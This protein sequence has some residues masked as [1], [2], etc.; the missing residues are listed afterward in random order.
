LGFRPAKVRAIPPAGERRIAT[1]AP[2]APPQRAADAPTG[3]V[4]GS[5]PE[6]PAL[7]DVPAETRHSGCPGVATL[8]AVRS[9]GRALP[10]T[11]PATVRTADPLREAARTGLAVHIPPRRPP[12]DRAT[13]RRGLSTG[14]DDM[15]RRAEALR[16][17]GHPGNDSRFPSRR[18]PPRRS[19]VRRSPCGAGRRAAGLAGRCG[20]R[21]FMSPSLSRAASIQMQLRRDD[22]NNCGSVIKKLLIKNA[23]LH[24]RYSIFPPAYPQAACP[25]ARSQPR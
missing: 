3:R 8:A 19:P 18:R 22:N 1:D 23:I 6:E 12:S 4:E 25:A 17:R 24:K 7:P 10:G 15:P 21:D 16:G 11:R 2:D 14:S 9:V 5:E 20:S 13:H